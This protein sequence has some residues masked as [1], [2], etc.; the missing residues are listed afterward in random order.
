[1]L[2]RQNNVVVS[3]DALM[4]T[5]HSLFSQLLPIS[6]DAATAADAAS[7]TSMHAALSNHFLLSCVS[8]SLHLLHSAKLL[9]RQR[10]LVD[11]ALA[12][13]SKHHAYLQGRLDVYRTYLQNVRQGQ[14]KG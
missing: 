7:T 13:V 5:L 12:T 9:A 3:I 8:S 6:A 11:T 14:A 10:S 1:M 4:I 2:A